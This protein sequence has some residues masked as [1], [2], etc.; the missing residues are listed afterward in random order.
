MP[1]S[2]PSNSPII[3]SNG[4]SGST[5]NETDSVRQ[6]HHH[7]HH[8]YDQRQLSGHVYQSRIYGSDSHARPHEHSHSQ[9][10]GRMS[11]ELVSDRV[12]TSERNTESGSTDQPHRIESYIDQEDYRF[13]IAGV[14]NIHMSSPRSDMDS[15]VSDLVDGFTH[16]PYST[17][18]EEL[19]DGGSDQ[20]SVEGGEVAQ[21]LDAIMSETDRSRDTR[22]EIASEDIYDT[23]HIMVH[24][25][26]VFEHQLRQA[27]EDY[28]E[29]PT[30]SPLSFRYLDDMETIDVP[31]SFE[32]F[33][34]NTTPMIQD[35]EHPAVALDQYSPTNNLHGFHHQPSMSISASYFSPSTESTIVLSSPPPGRVSGSFPYS[36]QSGMHPYSARSAHRSGEET[37]YSGSAL[38]HSASPYRPFVTGRELAAQQQQSPLDHRSDWPGAISPW[39]EEFPE[40]S[41]DNELEMDGGRIISGDSEGGHWSVFGSVTRGNSFEEHR[42]RHYHR[43][44]QYQSQQQDGAPTG[45]SGSR[46]AASALG[47]GAVTHLSRVYP[48]E[49]HHRAP[50]T[51][52]FPGSGITNIPIPS[53]YVN[54]QPFNHTQYTAST[55]SHIFRPRDIATAFNHHNG[56]RRPDATFDSSTNS[57]RRSVHVQPL[58]YSETIERAETGG[59]TAPNLSSTAGS[60]SSSQWRDLGQEHRGQTDIGMKEVIRM[61]CRFCETV[62]CERGM[63]VSDQSLC[64]RN[65][66]QHKIFTFNL[67][68]HNYWPITPLVS[69]RQMM[70]LIRKH[71]AI[72]GTL[73]VLFELIEFL[74]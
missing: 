39:E 34:S 47:L 32:S 31:Q 24:N 12:I 42:Y 49:S 8:P 53:R 54:P 30:R 59:W 19:I 26:R 17:Q 23:Q 11:I 65:P 21:I 73:R 69:C 1:G 55:G 62:I 16:S 33:H 29:S 27:R 61:A 10:N 71:T 66:R 9:L 56:Y 64:N 57:R 2:P 40:Q 48:Q 25:Q 51:S 5:V 14:S 63:R 46:P 43:Q 37:G 35:E 70:N 67:T 44:R 50:Q 7:H 41:S 3:D 28:S 18:V 36:T 68:R 20:Q 38:N 72:K 6:Y 52:S 45:V 74:F 58:P 4:D 13:M 22:E 15:Y 60:T